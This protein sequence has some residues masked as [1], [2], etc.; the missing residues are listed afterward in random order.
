MADTLYATFGDGAR[1]EHAVGALLDHGVQAEHVSLI[2]GTQPVR[3]DPVEQAKHGVSTTTPE[4]AAAGALQGAGV[5]LGFG[6]IAAALSLFLPG[7][8]LVTGGG[9]LA[10]AIAAAAASTAA[11]AAVGGVVG[12]LKDQGVGEEFAAAAHQ[13]V[14][15]GG[16]LIAVHVPSGPVGEGRAVEILHRYHPER[17]VAHPGSDAPAVEDPASPSG[18]A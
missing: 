5:G 3:P 15:R 7:I 13:T 9:A 8:G 18:G 12:F 1:A 4:D 6:A 17:L 16:V 2:A 14:Q 10:A 11:G